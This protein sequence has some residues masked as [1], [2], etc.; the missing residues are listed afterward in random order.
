MLVKE[1]LLKILIVFAKGCVCKRV[2]HTHPTHSLYDCVLGVCAFGY[3]LASILM[4]WW[5]FCYLNLILIKSYSIKKTTLLHV[6]HLLCLTNG[7]AWQNTYLLSG[8]K[9]QHMRQQNEQKATKLTL[10]LSFKWGHKISCY[11]MI[12]ELQGLYSPNNILGLPGLCFSA[13]LL[14]GILHSLEPWL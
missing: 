9:Q 5:L 3:K 7:V 11:M 2:L 13:S 1:P 12:P 8:D 14:R 6:V 10:F 4:C